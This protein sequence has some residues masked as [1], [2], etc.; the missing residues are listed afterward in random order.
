MRVS[1]LNAQKGLGLETEL[2]APS[3]QWGGYGNGGNDI[4]KGRGSGTG[5]LVVAILVVQGR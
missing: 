1:G 2:R 3:E 5:V 4:T